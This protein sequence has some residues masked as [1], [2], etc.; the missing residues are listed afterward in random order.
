MLSNVIA[1]ANNAYAYPLLIKHL[2]LSSLASTPNQEIIYRD[3]AR[4][5]Y[6]ETR[7]RIGRLA[8]GLSKLGVE[9]GDTVAVMDWDSHRYLECFFAVPMMGAVLFTVNVRLNP[10]QILYTLNHAGP[11]VLLVNAEF[12]PIIETIKDR[13][14]TVQKYVL[15]S[16]APHAEQTAVPLEC[17]YE[18]LLLSGEA[19]YDFPDF[20]E[21]TKATTFYTTGTTGLP[22]GVYFSHRQLVLHSLSAAA[23]LGMAPQQGRLHRA[24]VYMPITPMFHVHAWGLPYLATM[25]GLKQV[26]PGRYS[27]AGLL[28]LRRREGVTFSHCVPTI[29]HMILTHREIDSFDLTGW[30]IVIGGAALPTALASAALERGVDIFTGYGMSETCPMLTLAQ[31]KPELLNGVDDDGLALRTKTGLPVPL[32]DL[33]I[34]DP[35]MKDVAH[36]GKAS[37]EIVVRAPWLSQ[38]YLKDP[39]ASEALW[40]DGYLHTNDIGNIDANGYL[41]VTDRIKD[42]IKTGGEWISSL[43]V[44]DIISQHPAVSEVAVIGVKDEMWGERPKALVVLKADRVG[45]LAADDIRAFIQSYADRGLISKYGIPRDIVFVEQLTKTSVGKLNKR[46]LREAYDEN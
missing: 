5:T 11:K 44:E 32:V 19:H 28:E 22:K 17:E 18:I 8:S 6:R 29:L 23:A 45:A 34:V 7:E 16:D 2:L 3:L 10:E 36:D 41:Q 13:I 33:R 30:K 38:G 42:V 26:Y 20:D 35:D 15:I 9:P 37:G 1:K 27:P 46:A 39:E 43:E 31:L 21:N 12:L 14:E 40:S 4:H 24:D 25:A